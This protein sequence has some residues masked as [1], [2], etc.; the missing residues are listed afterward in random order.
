MTLDVRL[1]TVVL[2]IEYDGGDYRGFQRQSHAPSV[3]Q[4]V[5]SAASQVANEPIRIVGAG[6]TDTGVH[7][8][9]Q[10]VSFESSADRSV[11]A[12][13]RGVGSLTPHSIGVVWARVETAPFHARF[14][15]LWRRYVYVWSDASREPVILRRHVA[16]ARSPLD[17]D[18]MRTAARCLVGEH[19]F[20]AFRGAGC[21]SR[22][23]WRRLTSIDVSRRNG[24]V[25]VDVTANAFLKHMVRNIAGALRAVGSG[26]LTNPGFRSLFEGGDRTRGPATAPAHGLYL[27][28]VGYARW[29]AQ[30]RVPPML[31]AGR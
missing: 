27:V 19:D 15:A 22:S 4:A 30:I 16:W 8:T 14:D 9:L 25:V 26:A 5:E 13:R 29:P 6:R 21:Q 31:E 11:D 1:P 3:Q 2:G 23:P 17:A 20:S 7:A 12:W 10:V 24:Y 28:G 18:A